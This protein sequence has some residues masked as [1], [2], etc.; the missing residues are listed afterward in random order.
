MKFRLRIPRIPLRDIRRVATHFGPQLRPHRAALLAGAACLLGAALVEVA[1]PWPLK[2][3]F[4]YILI[5]RQHPIGGTVF[6]FLHQ[7]DPMMILSLAAGGILVVS[8]LS[9]VLNYAQTMI[10]G[11]I[12]HRVSGAIRLQLFAH[13]QRLPQSY[14]DHR[15][16]GDLLM[17]LTGDLTLLKDLL[18]SVLVTM[19]SRLVIVIGMLA[20]MLWV[21]P[22][23][24]LVA[25]GV[26][27][28]LLL[29]NTH[30]STRIRDASRRQ[31]RKEGELANSLHESMTGISLI[32]SFAQEGRQEKRFGRKVAGDVQAGLRIRRLEAAFSR[33]VD[34]ITALGI[35]AVLWFGV[36]RV[37]QNALSAGDLLI[38][39]SYLRSV[40]RPLR[41]MARLSTRTAKA[42]VAGQRIIDVLETDAPVH[43]QPG[44]VS[45]RD[46]RGDIRFECVGFSYYDG[47]PVLRNA[48]FH[49]P[50]QKTTAI[51]G[52]SGAGKS[53]VAK[54]ILR[55]Y[56][57][58]EGR[59]LLDGRDIREYVTRSVRKR[60]TSL[61]Q[62][63]TMFHASIREN[64]AFARPGA[65][66]D[67]IVAA[68][69]Q[70]GADE[71]IA[72]LPDGYETVIGEGGLTVSGGQRQRLAFARAALRN[73]P[74]MIFDE[75]ATG[76]DAGAEIAAKQALASL[77]HERTTV[78]ITHRLNFL[79][80]ADH[81]V[82]LDNG[83]VLE[84]GNP[85]ALRHSGGPFEQFVRHWYAQ[86][87]V[88]GDGPHE[89]VRVC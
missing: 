38:F 65:S 10:L 77:R 82:L 53:T 85:V 58:T 51:I 41:D 79:D 28:A 17:R 68:A 62:D 26:I 16:T 3:V 60:V 7:W 40:Y 48:S 84:E 35:C 63:I 18:V 55:L 46:I 47:H 66:M 12:G 32:K 67:D 54:L 61:S 74:V 71:F 1:R 24:T 13:I 59:I 39:T 5:P 86:L 22:P 14:H 72:Q 36:Q 29:A 21:D 81:V 25:L 83:I 4:D 50:E 69:K 80:L 19:G 78:I 37:M 57:P 64:V 34:V 11:N 8:L 76:L 27:P 52:A 31:R 9:G 88:P 15:Q 42:V 75:P 49:I 43:D 73:A 56:E 87:A 89:E 23:L 2:I 70:A 33:T 6:D 45:A 44:A 30:F 20:A